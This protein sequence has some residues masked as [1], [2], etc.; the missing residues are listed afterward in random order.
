MPEGLTE[1]ELLLHVGGI[2]FQDLFL[3]LLSFDWSD[4][5]DSALVHFQFFGRKK[6]L[7]SHAKDECLEAIE[8]GKCLVF[9]SHAG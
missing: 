2:E 3:A 8:A 9:E 5:W 7:L 6:L 4:N 1:Q